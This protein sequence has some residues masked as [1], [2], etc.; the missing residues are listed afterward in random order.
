MIDLPSLGIKGT[1]Q[2]IF[3]KVVE[4]LFAQG[5]KSSEYGV[6]VG[7]TCLY[8]GPNGTK[9]AIGCL[10]PD[11]RYTVMYEGGNVARLLTDKQYALYGSFLDTLQHVHDDYSKCMTWTE[12]MNDQ[13][14]IV[15]KNFDLNYTPR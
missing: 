7:E 6:N 2:E 4:H 11:N 1:Q 10:I 8:R 15:A 12:W 3:D 13:F 5:C 14:A 9:C